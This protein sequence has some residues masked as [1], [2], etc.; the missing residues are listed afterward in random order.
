MEANVLEEAEERT[1]SYFLFHL[2]GCSRTNPPV[3]NICIL[4]K[5]FLHFG[6][7]CKWKGSS[8]IDECK[9][10]A[11]LLCW[12]LLRILFIDSSSHSP[13]D[14]YDAS[15]SQTISCDFALKFT[16]DSLR[17]LCSRSSLFLSPCYSRN[18]VLQQG[19]TP[20]LPLVQFFRLM[21]TAGEWLEQKCFAED[22]R[23]RNPSEWKRFECTWRLTC[24]R[25]KS[26]QKGS[27]I[28]VSLM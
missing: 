16:R 17:S 23:S 3:R 13:L 2:S 15:V 19:V 28:N 25:I 1:I 8:R 14:V 12:A 11:A 5:A 22:R 9:G 10:I 18:S 6:D 7:R 4:E 27:I 21:K 26:L 20:S 24:A